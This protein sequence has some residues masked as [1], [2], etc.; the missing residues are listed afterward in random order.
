MP[1]FRERIV[2]LVTRLKE[3]G[4]LPLVWETYRSPERSEHLVA[5]GKSNSSGPSM[6]CYGVAADLVCAEHHWDC[7]KHGCGFFEALGKE[8]EKCGLTWGGRWKSIHD[9]PH[10]QGVRVDQ[11]AAI[12]SAKDHEAR[13]TLLAAGLGPVV[14]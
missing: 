1:A 12:R 6:H 13:E 11:Q 2:A 3:R 10:V 7:G 8:A 4:F 14:P 5:T 9:F